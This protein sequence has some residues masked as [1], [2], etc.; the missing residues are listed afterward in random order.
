MARYGVIYADPPWSYRAFR[1][2]ESRT[3]D[4]HYPVM[5]NQQIADYGERFRSQRS[6]DCAL[7]MWVTNPF[8]REG[9]DTIAAW[10]FQFKTVAFVWVKLRGFTPRAAGSGWVCIPCQDGATQHAV[11]FGMGHY[12]RPGAEV[13]LLATRGRNHVVDRSISQV[14]FAEMG[15]HSAKPAEVRC[16]IERMFPRRKRLELF[17]R[18]RVP[19]WDAWGNGVEGGR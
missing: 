10:G 7:F 4:A 12:T 6:K 5:T 14:V 17:A 2:K 19:K 9:L 13:C 11:H 15:E 18:E 1:D 16:R 3:A 8:L